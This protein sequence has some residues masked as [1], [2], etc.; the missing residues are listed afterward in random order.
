MTNEIKNSIKLVTFAIIT[1]L[2]IA[3]IIHCFTFEA[4]MKEAFKN[5]Y[6]QAILD[7]ELT[8]VTDSGYTLSFNGEEHYYSFS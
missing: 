8:G 3:G 7:A 6:E 1:A 2:A 4:K 5:G